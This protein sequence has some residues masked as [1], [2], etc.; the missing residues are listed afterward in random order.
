MGSGSYRYGFAQRGAV[1]TSGNTRPP[2]LSIGALLD[3]VVGPPGRS[4]RHAGFGV[5]MSLA[6][7][8]R[9]R[10]LGGFRHVRTSFRK[11]V[12]GSSAR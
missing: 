2:R 7:V 4:Q 8:L 11:P 3:H 9:W 5:E 10:Q 1:N 12:L 6:F